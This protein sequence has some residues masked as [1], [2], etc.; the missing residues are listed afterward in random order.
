MDTFARDNLPPRDQWP[1]LLELDYPE[2]LNAAS[3]LLSGPW[4]DRPCIL[5]D[6]E[7]WTYAELRSRAEAIARVLV[8]DMGLIRGNR[9]LL[10]GYND[11]QLIASWFGVLLAGGVAVATML[12]LRAGELVKV[13]SRAQVSHALVDA[14][15]A[16]EVQ[17]A[18]GGL[19][20][21]RTLDELASARGAFEP[22]ATSRDDVALIAFT[23]GTTG[24]PKGCVHFHR[25]VL[26]ICDTFAREILDPTPE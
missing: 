7:T 1:V 9:V 11:P 24:E 14:R 22:V 5:G 16:G 8:D 20:E 6:D 25:D 17:A 18:G 23:S 13:I 26:A 2:R 10:H 21:L 12:M 19:R 15:L 3:E 4:A